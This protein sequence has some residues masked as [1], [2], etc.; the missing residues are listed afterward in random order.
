MS[1]TG[2]GHNR[3]LRKMSSQKWVTP[4][5]VNVRWC[6]VPLRK[7]KYSLIRCF[8][9]FAYLSMASWERG[10]CKVHIH[11]LSRNFSFVSAA[12]SAS[13]FQ[14]YSNHLIT[15][16]LMFRLSE[17][18]IEYSGLLLV[19]LG[20]QWI[21]SRTAPAFSLAALSNIIKHLVILFYCL[22]PIGLTFED[23]AMHGTIA[24]HC[25]LGGTVSAFPLKPVSPSSTFVTMLNSCAQG[26]Q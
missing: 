23:N 16:M 13:A 12:W 19:L 25:W 6:S 15:T 4:R 22:E 3:Q 17:C 20:Q 2:W 8:L 5:N 14:G 24:Q 26:W 7:R 10:L 1:A 11:G 18:G 21:W 9:Y